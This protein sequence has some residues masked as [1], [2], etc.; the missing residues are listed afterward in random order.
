MHS[1]YFI[2]TSYKGEGGI[3]DTKLKKSM[4][5]LLNRYLHLQ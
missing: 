3:K 2:E 4:N 5:T 1:C